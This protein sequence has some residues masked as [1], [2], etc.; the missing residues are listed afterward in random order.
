MKVCCRRHESVWV[1]EGL[2][3]G[4]RIPSAARCA[5]SRRVVVESDVRLNHSRPPSRNRQNVNKGRQYRLDVEKLHAMGDFACACRLRSLMHAMQTLPAAC[6]SFARTYLFTSRKC[7][8][9]ADTDISS[10]KQ[11]S[12][13]RS[14]AVKH[15]CIVDK[16]ERTTTDHC[17]SR[18]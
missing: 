11:T 5:C 4:N 3:M 6:C 1:A 15:S 16:T 17:C 7:H 14:D 12:S 8:T 2:A 18:G 9:N 10:S 13:G